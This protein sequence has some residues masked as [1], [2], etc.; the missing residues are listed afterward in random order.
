MTSSDEWELT[1]HIAFP[2]L[3]SVFRL[4]NF[5]ALNQRLLNL[6]YQ[7]KKL[8]TGCKASNVLGWHS[9]GN[10]FEFGE[11][12]EFRQQVDRA[13]AQVATA[14]G[15]G[16]VA[17]SPANCW[18]NINPKYASN[19][20]HNHANCLF[21]G[22]YYVQ[23]PENCGMIMFYDPR[24]TKNFYSPRVKEYTAYTADALAHPAEA[25]TLII[26]PSWL[27]HGVEPNLSEQDRVSLSFNYVFSQ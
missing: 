22:V 12:Q 10:L 24:P 27:D 16:D 15:Y 20:I 19:K 26:F 17:I 14:M 7:V 23:T 4:H 25:G 9:Q 18:A 21:S 1:Q 5:E 2:T 13:V 3:L 8:D 11:M 6:I